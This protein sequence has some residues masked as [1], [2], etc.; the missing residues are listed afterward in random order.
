M[1][2]S[3][4]FVISVWVSGILLAYLTSSDNDIVVTNGMITLVERTTKIANVL[5]DVSMAPF[6]IMAGLP[7]T[8]VLRVGVLV[9]LGLTRTIMT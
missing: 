6:L 9:S 5:V 1:F 2:L 3:I 7:W 4:V 8:W